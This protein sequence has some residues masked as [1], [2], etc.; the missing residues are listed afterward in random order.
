[1]KNLGAFFAYDPKDT[2]DVRLEK[3]AAFL[4][5]GSCTLAGIIWTA[6]YYA[7]FGWGF[8]TM[9]PACF[10]VIVGGV[11]IISHFIRNH[12][13]T[14]YTQIICIIYIP[15]LIQW[16]IGGLFDSGFVLAWAFVGP[17]CALMFFSIKQSIPWFLLFVVNL[18][19]TII[20]N[21][22]FASRG[23]IVTENIRSFF[24]I[25][26]LGFASTVVFV[27]AS[28]YV[29]A[30]VKEQKKS[31]KLLEANLQQEIILRESEKLATLGKLSAGVAHELNN[32]AASMQR[33]TEQLRDA[34]IKLGKSEFDLGQLNLS[35]LQLKSLQSHTILIE[36]RNKAETYMDPIKRIDQETKVEAWLDKQG[37][38]NAWGLAPVLVTMGFD[39]EGLL[40]LAKQFKNQEF[41]MIADFLSNKYT[42]HNLLNEIK[43]GSEK[44]SE[45]VKAMKS[46][47]YLDQAPV[48]S[49][50]IHDGLND[51]LVMLKGY[52]KNGIQLRRDFAQNLPCIEAYGSELNQVWTNIIDNALNA[53]KENGELILKTYRENNWAVVEINDNGPGIPE[54]IQTKI[55]DPFFTTKP[56]GEGTGLG[57]YVSHNIIV[58]KHKGQISVH[59]EQGRTR[60]TVKLPLNLSD[61]NT[62]I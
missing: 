52:L 2:E 18:A 12:Q 23:Q 17:I 22:F 46:Y 15:S 60:F 1:M 50:D 33:G 57:L 49:V 27:F 26:N 62:S 7:I 3:V 44:I 21:D 32:P 13:Y 55:F 54:D 51:T 4:V 39:A 24:F 48:Q 34:I 36:Q 11:M 28:Y 14:I 56:P 20:F 47:A 5:S 8:T 37:L 31:S 10:V 35:A 45:I 19:I 6:M 41:Q 42:T 29:N 16:N 30:A 43:L 9:L 61:L 53:I 58:N 38:E 40:N 59:S 25:M